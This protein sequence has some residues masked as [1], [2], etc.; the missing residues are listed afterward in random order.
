MLQRD[1]FFNA[2]YELAKVNRDVIVVTADMGAEALNKFRVDLPDQFVNVG[3]A[4]QQAITLAAGLALEGKNVFVYGISPFVTYRCY[5]QIKVSIA[6]MCLPVTIVG[7][8][9]GFS[10]DDSGPTHHAVEDMGIMRMLPFF[11]VHNMTDSEM[12]GEFAHI[13]Y[14]SEVPSYVRLDREE[15]SS[16]S[17][18][19][20]YTKL[21]GFE[22]HVY[23]DDDK[24]LII[25]TGNMVHRAI[26]AGEATSASVIDVFTFP[27]HESLVGAISN[28]QRIIT[29]E[30]HT[31]PGGLGSAV[32]E[33]LSDHKLNIPVTRIGL[34]FS[35]GYCYKYGGRKN[36]QKLYGLDK[37]S[38]IEVVND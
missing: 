10:Y 7:C 20:D 12:A 30:E 31:L 38:I 32:L 28:P 2:V 21:K 36:L 6:S 34:D 8:G 29:L 19:S 16:I 22:E 13:C 1:A 23:G 26:E 14:E 25:A 4:E 15:F 33:F 9:A 35:E 18:N 17:K 27:I 24:P 37:K 3:I 11:R 5:D